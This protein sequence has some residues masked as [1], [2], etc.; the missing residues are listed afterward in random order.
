[1]RW[2]IVS[3]AVALAPCAAWS[4]DQTKQESTKHEGGEK[5]D[6][7]EKQQSRSS[8]SATQSSNPHPGEGSSED[9][10]RTYGQYGT[11]PGTEARSEAKQSSTRAK[12]STAPQD[13]GSGGDTNTNSK[14]GKEQT[15]VARQP[16]SVTDNARRD[17]RRIEGE[18]SERSSASTSSTGKPE[19]SSGESSGGASAG[20]SSQGGQNSRL[21]SAGNAER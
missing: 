7:G 15:S 2:L 20:D 5:H 4:N 1:M 14:S 11:D 3:L 12:K 10:D 21:G 18:S 19:G 6:S 9:I 13:E 8:A 17:E 16:P